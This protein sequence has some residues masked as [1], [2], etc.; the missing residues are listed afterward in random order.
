MSRPT[1]ARINLDHLRH[2]AGIAAGLAPASRLMAVI[3]A[4]AYGHGAAAVAHA[5]EDSVAAFAVASLEEAVHLRDR[6]IQRPI[7]LLEG[8][9]E[10][11]DL[12]EAAAIG[13]WIMLT[14]DEQLHWL[15]DA[16]LTQALTCWLKLDT[17][18]HRLGIAPGR[19]AA[20]LQA[21][22]DTPNAG[23]D[24]VLCTHFSRADELTQ[25][26]TREQLALFLTTC[27]GYRCRRSAANSPAILAWPETHLDWIRPGYMLY[28]DS[29]FAQQQS[30]AAALKP[31]MTLESR[32]IGVRDIPAGDAVGYGAA[33]RAARPSRIATVTAGYADGYPRSAANG[34]PVLVNGQRVA[35]VGRVSMDMLTLDVTD[36]ASVQVGDPVTLWGE[37][38]PVGEVARHA[39]SIGYELLARMPARVPR[40]ISA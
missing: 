16:R 3:K 5:L 21:L 11:R 28:G 25:A 40:D 6:G 31:V 7:L 2:N 26:E 23:P 8:V 10:A 17:G 4:N 15:R 18:M 38:L 35:L 36:L 24:T 19:T 33:W 39:S 1:R 29:P 32:V 30:Q 20:F 34:T 9:F 27:E 37:G 12:A 22:R 14:C 13:A